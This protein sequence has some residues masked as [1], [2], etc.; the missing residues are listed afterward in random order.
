MSGKILKAIALVILL[1]SV[2]KYCKWS[3]VILTW[4]LLLATTLQMI[5]YHSSILYELKNPSRM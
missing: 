1:V 2:T 5:V 3:L 4:K